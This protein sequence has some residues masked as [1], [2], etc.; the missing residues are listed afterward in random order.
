VTERE[1]NRETE[2][3]VRDCEEKH[4]LVEYNSLIQA[5]VTQFLLK[6]QCVSRALLSKFILSNF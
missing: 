2:S 1:E 6:I 5:C 4:F 3:R